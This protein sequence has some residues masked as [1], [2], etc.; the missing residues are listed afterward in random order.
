MSKELRIPNDKST[1]EQVYFCV[2]VS[3]KKNLK[4]NTV[5]PSSTFLEGPRV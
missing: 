2:S 4:F 3:Q 5:N 1:T